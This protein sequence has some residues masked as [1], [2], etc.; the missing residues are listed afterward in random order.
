MRLQ[1]FFDEKPD[2]DTRAILKKNGFR[3]APSQN[4][5][6]QRHLNNGGKYALDRVIEEIEV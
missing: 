5:A 6:W 1:L 2:A 4:N 3:F